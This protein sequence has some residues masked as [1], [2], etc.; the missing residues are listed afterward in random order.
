MT[1]LTSVADAIADGGATTFASPALSVSGSNKV[2][3]ALAIDS[4]TTPADATGVVWDAAG[5]NEALTK[6]GAGL[7][8]GTFANCSLWRKIAPSDG[9]SKAVTATWAA[10]KGERGL[11]VWVE[12][13]I[14]QG[15]PNG[16][17]VSA[18]GTGTSVA[19]GAVTTTVG[20]RV[21]QLADALRTGIFSAAPNFNTPTGTERHDVVSTGTAYHAIAAQ[22]Q[23]ASGSS[24]SPSWATLDDTTDGWGTFAFAVNAASSATADQEGARFG[25]DDGAEAAHTW[26]AAQDTDITAPA[27]QT[28]TV[29]LIVNTTG[30]LG[31]KTFKLQYRKV[32]AS[33]W[34]DMPVQ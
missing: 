11:I 26:A 16:T 17:V 21:I 8:Y 18:T 9:T 20:Q 24:T 31:A 32:G 19:S 28:Q 33:D 1:Y 12:T 22:E 3:W 34:L 10:S 4:D 15:T 5:V 6:L 23:T 27:G 29:N 2:M 25:N 14:D 7:T 13:D 30:T